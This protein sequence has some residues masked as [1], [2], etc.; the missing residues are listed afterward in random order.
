MRVAWDR[1]AAAASPPS[2]R[3]GRRAPVA[4]VVRVVLIRLPAKP[5]A[6]ATVAVRTQGR[7]LAWGKT[8]A[9]SLPPGWPLRGRG[10]PTGHKEEPQLAGPESRR[11]IGLVSARNAARWCAPLPKP[12]VRRRGR[13]GA[14]AERWPVGDAQSEEPPLDLPDRMIR[15]LPGE[16]GLPQLPRLPGRCRR[17]A[18]PAG[19]RRRSAHL[20]LDPVA[21]APR[22]GRKAA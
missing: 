17:L 12:R 16:G 18:Q 6:G 20:S 9:R 15:R 11:R 2:S 4:E 21:G 19:C 8:D 22:R 3:G 13:A 7:V 1:A 14:M 10:E 5:L